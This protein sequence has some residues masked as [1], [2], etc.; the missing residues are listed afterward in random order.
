MQ[1]RLSKRSLF[2]VNIR[3]LFIASISVLSLTIAS[4]HI[5]DIRQGLTCARLFIFTHTSAIYYLPILWKNSRELILYEDRPQGCKFLRDGKFDTLTEALDVLP[6]TCRICYAMN[7]DL[8]YLPLA[9]F[10][11]GVRRSSLLKTIEP[12][13]RQWILQRSNDERS[14]SAKNCVEDKQFNGLPARKFSSPSTN[15]LQKYMA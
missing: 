13:S 1:K 9:Y 4:I 12:R 8:S 6:F 2:I 11:N 3:S 14:L 7:S 10:G 15:A 5:C